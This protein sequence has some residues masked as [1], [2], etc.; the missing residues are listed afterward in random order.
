MGRFSRETSRFA[1]LPVQIETTKRLPVRKSIAIL[2]A[3][4]E[5][6]FQSN[7]NCVF[8]RVFEGFGTCIRTAKGMRRHFR[9]PKWPNDDSLDAELPGRPLEGH[10]IMTH[11][12]QQ[13]PSA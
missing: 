6:L 5:I 13:A 7:V 1:Q 9:S 3:K 11:A 12:T 8:L 10:Q 2:R 4:K